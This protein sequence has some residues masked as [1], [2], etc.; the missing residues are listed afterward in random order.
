MR[1]EAVVDDAV[2]VVVDAVAELDAAVGRLALAAVGWVLVGVEE[3]GEAGV[4]ARPGDAGRV[5]VHDALVEARAAVRD[6]G[7]QLGRVRIAES[8]A[9]RPVPPAWPPVPPMPPVPASPD[10]PPDVWRSG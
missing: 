7:L 4:L 1:V 10:L 8:D 2:A 6:V 9:P 5:G 3:A